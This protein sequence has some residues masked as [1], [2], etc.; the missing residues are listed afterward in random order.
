MRRAL[1]TGATGQ[2]G[3]YIA[4]R[5]LAEGYAVRALVRDPPAADWLARLGVELTAGDIADT[6]SLARAAEG[7]DALVHAAAVV[8]APGGWEHY[9]AINVDGTRAVV[10]AAAG[11]G[12]RLVHISSVAVY[13]SAERY[14]ATPTGED[15]PLA[16]LPEHAVYARSKREAESLVLAAHATGRVWACALRPD[17][18]Y[19]RRDRQFVPR[20]A[21]LLARGVAPLV[22]G[23]RARMAIVHASAVADAAARA[24]RTDAAGGRAYNVANDFDVTVRDFLQLAAAGLGRRVRLLPIPLPLAR[25]AVAGARA[26]VALLRGPALASH[27]GSSLDFITRDNPFTSERARRELGWAPA[28]RPDDGIPEAFRWWTQ[29]RRPRR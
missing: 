11:A 18:I 12:A 19:G 27:V 2:V 6:A 10:E 5:L 9:R 24:L 7:C 20:V 14:R 13:G 25:A 29:Q 3:S 26:G 17:V 8:A 28:M 23:G 4:E 15:T 21:H 22:A 1:V 16:R